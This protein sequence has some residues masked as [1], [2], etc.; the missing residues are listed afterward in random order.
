M[1]LSSGADGAGH[2]AGMTTGRRCTSSL[3]ITAIGMGVAIHTF[4]S[5]FVVVRVPTMPLVHRMSC[6][7]YCEEDA[8]SSRVETRARFL[9]P[10]SIDI[11][12]CGPPLRPSGTPAHSGCF[13]TSWSQ[14]LLFRSR[15]SNSA[16][17]VG[18]AAERM[19]ESPPSW[20]RG[21]G[22]R[23]RGVAI[24]LGRNPREKQKAGLQAA[25][26]GKYCLLY[27]PGPR[28]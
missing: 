22:T 26:V 21:I 23:V 6:C 10:M 16:R 15:R 5:W 27:G 19:R 3:T 14:A 11:A 12:C 28:A 4:S 17:A 20:L 7:L 8:A 24:R 18:A 25:S 2:R 1:R 13:E 9:A